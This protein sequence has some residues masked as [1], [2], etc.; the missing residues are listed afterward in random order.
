[1][2]D[3]LGRA[4]ISAR[5][6]HKQPRFTTR[7]GSV[8]I[9]PRYARDANV[10]ND[11]LMLTEF[12]S[13]SDAQRVSLLL[14]KLSAYGLR[15]AALVGSIATEVHLHSQGRNTE[16]RPLNDLDF[17]VESFTSLPASLA[18]GFLV[19]HIHPHAPEGKLL[20]QLIDRE[21]ALRIDLFRQFGNT[22]TRVERR[23]WL[24]ESVTLISLEDLVARTTA[25][26]LRSLRTGRTVDPKHAHSFRRLVGLGERR[27]IDAAWR[28]HR[29]SERT[30]FHDAV[31]LAQCLLD[32]HPELAIR[33]PYS[34][35]VSVCSKCED[36]GPFR[37]ARPDIIVQTLG[38]W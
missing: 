27:R 32:L 11:W 10:C 8:S 16:L 12:L 18:D 29:Q 33:E 3:R 2:A 17:I 14:E 5:R 7:R 26:L 21:Q 28:D 15:G 37:R 1:M 19:H 20:L 36:H 31:Q 30:S 34:S 35:E 38:Y 25:L 23:T 9:L 22:L 24:T 13:A 4:R 6:F